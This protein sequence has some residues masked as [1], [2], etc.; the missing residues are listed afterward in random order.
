MAESGRK[1]AHLFSDAGQEF[2]LDIFQK[3]L[4]DHGVHSYVNKTEMKSFMVERGIR[5]LMTKLWKILEYKNTWTY[6]KYL[7]DVVHSYNNSVHSTTGLKPVDVNEKNE[8][9][10]LNKLNKNLPKLIGKPK[11]KVGDFASLK[12]RKNP[13]MKAYMQT[14]SNATYRVYRVSKKA[15]VYLYHLESMTG[16]KILGGFYHF[17]LVKTL[18]TED[19]EE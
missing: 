11:F 10:L 9:W 8:V 15:P 14:F 1:L 12:Y 7:D 19:T 3:M 13:F 5:S 4:S 6:L 16:D 2:M 17:E 18:L